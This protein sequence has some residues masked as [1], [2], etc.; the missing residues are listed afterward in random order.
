MTRINT[1]ID[2]TELPD[3]LL[4]AEHREITRIP[5]AVRRGA[6]MADI[7]S[8]FRLGKGHVRF[9]YDKLEYLGDR[10]R[11]LLAECKR[12]G[13][14]VT[15]RSSAFDGMTGSYVE[16]EHDREIV[17]ARIESRGFHLIKVDNIWIQH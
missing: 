7:P 13:F 16:T 3:K 8:T 2:P 6:S 17:V 15:D 14:N 4:L 1:G 9:F 10:Y 5:N 12:R 11:R